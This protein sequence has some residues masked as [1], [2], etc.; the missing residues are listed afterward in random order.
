MTVVSLLIVLL[1]G[2]KLEKLLFLSDSGLC[3]GLQFRAPPLE[4]ERQMCC[5]FFFSFFFF[6]TVIGS[7]SKGT[8]G[9]P[10]EGTDP[11]LIPF[12]LDILLASTK[13]VT[14][15]VHLNGSSGNEAVKR[16]LQKAQ[17]KCTD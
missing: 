15:E 6:F 2:A 8:S 1:K 17:E 13:L 11:T 14:V 10:G 12:A 16:D 9:S 5:S 4:S 3:V 7:Y